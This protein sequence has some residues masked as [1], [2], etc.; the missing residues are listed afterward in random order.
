MT[1]EK[2][3]QK[4]TISFLAEINE[5]D[6]KRFQALHQVAFKAAEQALAE[7]ERNARKCFT[8]KSWHDKKTGYT[9]H[10][11]SCVKH[12]WSVEGPDKE[13]ARQRAIHYLQQYWADGEYDDI[14]GKPIDSEES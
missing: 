10:R 1:N 8:Y 9:M 13:A 5:E 3:P 12:L 4:W 7:Q 2:S 11:F 6:S 14:L